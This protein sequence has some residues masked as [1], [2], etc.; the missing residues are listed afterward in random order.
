MAERSKAPTASSVNQGFQGRASKARILTSSLNPE[1]ASDAGGLKP[2]TGGRIPSIVR[3][4]EIE[5]YG[6]SSIDSE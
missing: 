2:I 1:A 4:P 6:V 3:F 5:L